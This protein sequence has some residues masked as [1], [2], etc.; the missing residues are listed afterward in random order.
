MYAR[1]PGEAIEQLTRTLEI[2]PQYAQA[3]WR[4]I[5]ALL[6]AGR[7]SEAVTEAERVVAS[8]NRSPAALS[9]LAV[10]AAHDGRTA[11]ARSLLD[12]LLDLSRREYV[13][14]GTIADMYVALGDRQRAFEWMEKA[15]DERSNWVAYIAGDPANDQLRDE[16]YFQSL[17]KRVGL[18]AIK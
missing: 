1:R 7:T 11:R 10:A 16:P 8:G 9:I 2:D 15:Y 13:P 18:S 5:K 14:A 3:R 4:L 6:L 12:M 17:L